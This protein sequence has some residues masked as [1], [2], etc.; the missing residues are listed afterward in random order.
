V[1][2]EWEWKLSVMSP[3]AQDAYDAWYDYVFHRAAWLPP[4][5]EVLGQPLPSRVMGMIDGFERKYRVAGHEKMRIELA[6]E[7]A[8]RP[9]VLGL[10]GPCAGI[11]LSPAELRRKRGKATDLERFVKLSLEREEILLARSPARVR[12]QE[13]FGLLSD[14]DAARLGGSAVAKPRRLRGPKHTQSNRRMR[15]HDAIATWSGRAEGL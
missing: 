9:L 8:L 1:G 13:R 7:R 10:Y 11:E 2:E 6:V 3:K 4:E 12:V 15:K 5:F 14:V